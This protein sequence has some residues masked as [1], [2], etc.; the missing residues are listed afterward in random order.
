MVNLKKHIRDKDVQKNDI[1]VKSMSFDDYHDHGGNDDLR[2]KVEILSW[3]I[4]NSTFPTFAIDKD[5]KVILWNKACEVLTGYNADEVVGTSKHSHIFE[6]EEAPVLADLIIDNLKKDKI[7]KKYGKFLKKSLYSMDSYEGE[8]CFKNIK[9]DDKWLLFSAGP[10]RNSKGKVIFAVQSLI[11]KTD[12]KEKEKQNRDLDEKLTSLCSTCMA[13][14]SSLDKE[15][16]LNSAIMDISKSL[17]VDC[18]CLFI[19]ESFGKFSLKFS[20][21]ISDDLAGKLKVIGKNSNIGR[22]AQKGELVIIEDTTITTRGEQGLFSSEGFSSLAFLPIWARMGNLFGVIIIG[23]KGEKIFSANEI[24]IFKLIGK[25]IGIAI[26]NIMFYDHYRKLGEKYNLLFDTDPNPIFILDDNS[27]NV[28]D[29]NRRAIECYGFEKNEIIGKSFLELG[30]EDDDVVEN[31]LKKLE[32]GQ[33]TFFSKKR[34]Y[35]K[36]KRPF[37]VNINVCHDKYMDGHAFIATTTDV[38]DNVEKE[39]KLIQAS[40]MTT[41]GTMVAGMAH[42]INQPLNVIQVGV[43]FFLKK[44]KKGEP[45]EEEELRAIS[46]E[47]NNSVNRA[48]SIINHMRAFAR[49]SDVARS[50]ININDPINDVFKVLGQQIRV[51]QVELDLNLQE[52]LPPI[53]AD[54]NRLE[55]VFMNLITN[56]IY[57]L[58]KKAI[59]LGKTKWKKMLAIRSYLDNDNIVVTVSDTG[60]GMSEVVSSKIFEP[61]FTTKVVGEGTGLGM[62]ISYGIIKDYNGTII[63]ESEVDEGTIFMLQFPACH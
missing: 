23:S 8:A 28:L 33:C 47:M 53:M 31:G 54:H 35:K 6:L 37:Y 40:K 50:K 4:D 38:T 44:I 15:D 19:L 29:I 24:K 12:D 57:A 39:A 63:V 7:E 2:G 1:N 5:H 43:D 60:I 41:L 61:F 42:E 45:I 27:F 58:D 49:Q 22:V 62:S 26:E 18:L 52:D 30:D 10:I 36:G 55:Q 17:L 21:G 46:N 16:W 20:H 3:V 25:R 59:K 11:D 56:A 13:L 9:S 14:S 34:H 32:D 51:H 48:T